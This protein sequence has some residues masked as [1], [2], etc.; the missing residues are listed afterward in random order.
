[1]LRFTDDLR[2]RYG[3]PI[4]SAMHTDVPGA[5]VGFVDALAAGRRAVPVRGAQ[6]GRPVGAV[7]HRR[8]GAGPPVLVAGAGRQPGAGLVHRHPARHGVHGGQRGRARGELRG[9]RRPAARLPAPGREPPGALRLRGVRV[10]R[11]GRGGADQAALPARPAA[12]AGAGRQRR[13]RRPVDRAAVDRARLERDVGLPPPAAGHEHATSSTR[14]SARFGDRIPEHEGDWTDWWADGLGSGA[15]PLGYAR[16]RRHAVRRRGDAAPA[17]RRRDAA[18]AVD[19]GLRPA[20]PVRRAHLGR[21]Q[22][23]ARPRG[24]LRLGRDAVGAQVRDGVLAPPTTPRTCGVA[25]GHRLGAQLRGAGGHAGLAT[26]SPTS[27]RPTGPTSRR[28]SSR[29]APCRWTRRCPSWTPAP[30]RR[31]PHH[32]EEQHPR[33]WPT[34]PGGRRVSF[35]AHDVPATGHVRFDVRAGVEAGAGA[36]R[37]RPGRGRSRTSST[38]STSTRGPA[39]SP[40]SSTSAAGRELVNAGGVRGHRTST[41]TTATRPRRTSTTSPATSRRP[42]ATWRCSAARCDRA[43]RLARPGR[44]HRGRRDDRDRAATARAWTGCAPRS[45]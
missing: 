8:P 42:T 32:E 40:R 38:A 23:V 22:P 16:G 25:G 3:V 13:Q 10:E 33:D 9:R 19:G 18:A 44:A 1:M 12:P 2:D 41:S 43:A 14:R 11:A 39:R 15:R 45:R 37:A 31:S 27:G 26:W 6:L 5:V 30:A 35:V 24:R 21:R 28:S 17:R 4:T 34:R 7:P 20:R 36:R 29:P